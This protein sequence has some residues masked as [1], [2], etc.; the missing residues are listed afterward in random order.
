M[1]YAVIT[2]TDGNFLIRSEWGDIEGA[3]KA[4][5]SLASALWADNAGFSKGYIAILDEN[6]DTVEGYKEYITH[7]VVAVAPVEETPTEE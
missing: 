7:P 4:Y 1:R 2:V 6:L 5:F 3:K